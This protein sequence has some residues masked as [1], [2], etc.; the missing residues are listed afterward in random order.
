MIDIE[1]RR[2]KHRRW[3][4]RNVERERQRA[5]D[6]Y[7]ADVHR[8]RERRKA[9][10]KANPDKVKAQRERVDKARMAE[11][12]KRSR[13]KHCDKIKAYKRE[14]YHRTKTNPIVLL[15]SRIRV[16]LCMLMRRA[17]TTKSRRA[18]ELLGC[19]V[20]SFKL[21]LESKFEPGMSWQN[22][23]VHG[24]HIDHIVPVS[25]FDLT[26][27]D[28]QKVCF[29]FSNLQPLWALDN[30]R[31]GAKCTSLPVLLRAPAAK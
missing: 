14:Y 28:H 5:R 17:I 26:S 30:I 22:Y 15:R 8:G 7:Y 19:S 21:Y 1:K 25:L 18:V 31:K 29:H 20:E 6:Y 23:G 11:S 16:R 3:R 13:I 2:A 12:K 24:W 10:S 9:W 4:A 27:P